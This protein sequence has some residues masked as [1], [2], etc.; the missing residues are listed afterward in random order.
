MQITSTLKDDG[1]YV[2]ISPTPKKGFEIQLQLRN[3]HMWYFGEDVLFL[4]ILP[5][6]SYL[7]I[8]SYYEVPIQMLD[9]VVDGMGEP[10]M[11]WVK[12]RG[13]LQELR[14]YVWKR[15]QFREA[16]QFDQM[17]AN[18]SLDNA[19][20]PPSYQTSEDFLLDVL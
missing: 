19:A 4:T 3:R 11:V 12:H 7:K 1:D 6:Y 18:L 9:E 20:V 14:D 13:G 17:M 5:K 15:D 2:P 8:D 16:E 10:L